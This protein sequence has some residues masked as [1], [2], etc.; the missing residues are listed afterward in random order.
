MADTQVLTIDLNS[1]VSAQDFLGFGVG[2]VAYVR[3]FHV[4]NKPVFA[5]HAADGTPLSVF[6]TEAAALEALS[7]NNLDPVRVH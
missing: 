1:M 2:E 3:P 7:D 6:D 5:V 4:M